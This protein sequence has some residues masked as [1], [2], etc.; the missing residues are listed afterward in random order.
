MCRD[1]V[2][3]AARKLR[4]RRAQ[5]WALPLRERGGRMEGVAVGGD[6]GARVRCV[7]LQRG[8]HLVSPPKL[9]AGLLTRERPLFV[10]QLRP[11]F[12]A[13]EFHALAALR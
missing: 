2:G 13:G 10:V 1:V 3:P 9:S 8:S 7:D 6:E 12:R 4:P 5:R 11:G